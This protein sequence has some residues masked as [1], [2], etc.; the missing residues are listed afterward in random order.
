MSDKIYHDGELLGLDSEHYPLRSLFYG[1]GVF[2]TFRMRGHAPRY[3]G[4][5]LERMQRG[6]EQLGIP[7]PGN[8]KVIEQMDISLSRSGLED[9]YVKICLLSA[10]ESPFYLTPSRGEVWVVL[11]PYIPYPRPSMRATISPIRRNSSSPAVGIKSL[12][13]LD[14]ILAR[15]EAIARG[16]DEAILLNERDVVAE[17]ASTNIFW[18]DVDGALNTPAPR[19]GLLPGVARSVVLETARELGFSLNEGEFSVEDLHGCQAAFLT[20]SV[21]GII[22]LSE[23]DGAR[24]D[25]GH[26]G[27]EGRKRGSGG[28]E[29]EAF[30]ALRELF[31]SRL[32]WE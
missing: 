19:V 28:G 12:N 32:G 8:E 5:H 4:K 11:R 22:P 30:A 24:F 9:A 25:E 3:I 20:N 23:L 7:F 2:E 31:M 18:F 29:N 1:E 27:Q 26:G 17:G 6:A 15:R 14:S 13:Y 10:G 21:M 16:F